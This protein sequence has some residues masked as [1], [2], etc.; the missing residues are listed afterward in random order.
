MNKPSHSKAINK[1]MFILLLLVFGAFGLFL[2]L[3]W[4]Y[5]SDSD[6][7]FR[8]VISE[9][10]FANGRDDLAIMEEWGFYYPWAVVC[11]LVYLQSVM[12]TYLLV[13][14]NLDLSRRQWVVLVGLLIIFIFLPI[15]L[16][17]F[18]TS[19]HSRI[20]ENLEDYVDDFVTVGILI[21]TFLLLFASSILFFVKRFRNYKKFF[22]ISFFTVFLNLVFIYSFIEL[23]FD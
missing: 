5:I 12:M 23:F 18:E 6:L 7:H 21:F 17:Y 9:A 22:V 11:F 20:L 13:K 10:I 14:K 19:F 16:E 2:I 15:L 4:K 3:N 8:N 1:L